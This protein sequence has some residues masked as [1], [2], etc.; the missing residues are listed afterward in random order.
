MQS[1]RLRR[2][3]KEGLSAGVPT[4]I[5]LDG[6]GWGTNAWIAARLFGPSGKVIV[7]DLIEAMRDNLWCERFLC[8]RASGIGSRVPW[9]TTGPRMRPAGA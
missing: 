2:L 7:L 8:R 3:L 5:V 1:L 4:P 9:R 6:S